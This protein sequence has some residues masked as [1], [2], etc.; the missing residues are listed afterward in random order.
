[1]SRKYRFVLNLFLNEDLLLAYKDE[2][3]AGPLRGERLLSVPSSIM[4]HFTISRRCKELLKRDEEGREGRG[5]LGGPVPEETPFPPFIPVPL[6]DGSVDP[7]PGD[8]I[9]RESDERPVS[10][11]PQARKTEVRFE[12]ARTRCTAAYVIHKV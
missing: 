5:V 11:R 9:G 3:V 8:A 1:M 7:A 4:H 12:P 6:V 10:A 2:R